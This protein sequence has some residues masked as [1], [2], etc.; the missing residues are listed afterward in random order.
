MENET[1]PSVLTYHEKYVI[2]MTN[3]GVGIAAIVVCLIAVAMALKFK[4]HN[5][6]IHRL[7]IYQVFSAMLYSAVRIV[8][9]IFINYDKNPSVYHPICVIEGFVLEYTLWIKL[10]FTFCLTFHLFCLSVFHIKLARLE[11]VYVLLSIFGP[12][13]FTWVPFISINSSGPLYGVAGAWCWIQN[14]KD[15]NASIKLP[16][17][18]IEQYALLYAPA[19]TCL[20]LCGVAVVI[21][22]V[23][24]VCQAYRSSCFCCNRA[25]SEQQPLLTEKNTKILKEILPLI[26]YPI[27]SL[28]FYIPAFIN[29]LIG[30]I[31]SNANFSSF[32]WSAVSLP[33]VGL[34]AGVSLIAHI[35]ILKCTCPKT[36]ETLSTA[37][38]HYE[39]PAESAVDEEL[40]KTTTRSTNVDAVASINDHEE[41]KKMKTKALNIDEIGHRSTSVNKCK[42]S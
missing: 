38:T 32:I 5:F 37:T 26:I 30:S 9:V 3:C 35:F 17:G 33:L 42:I 13:L 7:A 6:F 4:L 40:P 20:L 27:L 1:H 34:L 18:E 41:P 12:L 10:M 24:L 2:L 36:I 8:E 15:D 16:Q 22:T 11:V 31:S 23:I 25:N 39:P 21:I 29:R 28:L 19:I 14:W